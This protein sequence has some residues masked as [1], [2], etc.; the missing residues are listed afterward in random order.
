LFQQ[1]AGGNRLEIPGLQEERILICTKC[2]ATLAENSRFCS[3]CG[4]SILEPQ[5]QGTPSPAPVVAPETSGKAVASLILGIIN[6]FPLC[7]VAIVLG[8]ISLSQ[9]KKSAGRLKGEGLAIAGLILGYLGLVAIPFILIVAAIAIPNLLRARIPAN[10]ASAAG[11]VRNLISAEIS[12]QS[13]HPQAGFTCNLSDLGSAGLIDSRL[14]SG[15]K[16]GYI[17]AL[18]NCTAEKEGDP[19]SHFQ[20]TASP[21]TYNSTGVRQFCA[22]ESGVIRMDNTGSAQCVDHGAPL[23]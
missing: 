13:T 15:Q 22:D 2:G 11:S 1:F 5:A 3:I 7:I 16:T 6:V 4:N 8:H 21:V 18:Q 12:Y 9:I 10:E 20:I 23:E 14:A 17:F 19:A